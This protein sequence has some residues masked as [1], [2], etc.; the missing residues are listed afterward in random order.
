[1]KDRAPQ[2][3]RGPDRRSVDRRGI[4]AAAPP[5]PV[6]YGGANRRRRGVFRY[7]RVYYQHMRHDPRRERLFLSSAAFALTFVVVRLL[8]F[9]I[10]Y[11]FG[12]FHNVS[13]GG[14]HVHH[15]VWG[16]LLM[17]VVAYTWLA[18][19]GTSE[20]SFDW[21]SR[22]SPLAFG[23]AAAL[24]LDEFALWLQLKDVY[25]QQEG[26]V[27]VE[28][29]ALAF[30]LL[31]FGIWGGPLLVW[32]GRETR[33]VAHDVTGLFDGS[34]LEYRRARRAEKDGKTPPG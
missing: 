10:H 23:V 8:V 28:V 20:P 17:L 7:L 30:G 9:S 16:I 32:I 29:V 19:Y 12:P 27:S 24:I 1:M 5:D 34:Y 25:W 22:I 3:R 4:A 6:A 18:Q 2:D 15:L 21:A 14:T 33:T 11:N 26:R 31:S 13:V